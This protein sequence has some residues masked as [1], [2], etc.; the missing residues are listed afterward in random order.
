[1]D[2]RN[3]GESADTTIQRLLRRLVTSTRRTG[4]RL[5]FGGRAVRTVLTVC[6]LV[7]VVSSAVVTPVSAAPQS[8][9][10]SGSDGEWKHY[11]S[12][13][14]F[15]NDDIQPYYRES[16]MR[17]VDSVFVEEGVPVTQ[18]V[19]PNVADSGE[20][21]HDQ[22]LCQYL[23]AQSERH[24]D[25]FE[26]A[27]HGYTHNATTTFYGSSEFGEVAYE[28]QYR[29]ISEGTAVIES[30][31]G[32]RPDTFVPPFDTYDNETVRALVRANFTTVSGGGWFTE[33]YYGQ[34]EPFE[35]GGIHHVPNSQPFVEDWSTHAFYSDDVLEQQFD[36]SY[37]N[38]SLYV[39]MIHYQTF[40]D[41]ERLQ[42]LRSLI[43]HMKSKE[44]VRFTTLGEFTEQSR[45]DELKRVDDGWLVWEPDTPTETEHEQV[46][47]T[48]V[49]TNEQGLAD[50]APMQMDEREQ[51]DTSP[52][53]ATEDT[54]LKARF[55][56]LYSALVDFVTQTLA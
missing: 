19:I 33:S 5:A 14:V 47:D 45:Q 37:R 43:H 1:M 3:S 22:R 35:S 28:E 36:A 40:T 48:P 39:Q 34:T 52:V 27:L 12:L 15:R 44:G 50:D 51:G 10:Q 54:S 38:H 46:D 49:N 16:E 30:C 24:P 56:R 23:R 18:G 9:T 7:L 11:Q 26:F 6:L 20:I 2:R 31:T 41:D 13:V 17:A 53:E 32:E 8:E 4:R 25:I 55:D 21:A 29:R 42:S